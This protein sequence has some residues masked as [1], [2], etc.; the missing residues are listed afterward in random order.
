MVDLQIIKKIYKLLQSS[1][2]TYKYGNK[3]FIFIIAVIIISMKPKKPKSLSSDEWV[4]IIWCIHTMEK[5]VLLKPYTVICDDRGG[6]GLE[7]KS[8]KNCTSNSCI[9]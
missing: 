4:N 2:L 6:D 5:I 3:T 1:S 7:V 9:I 8:L